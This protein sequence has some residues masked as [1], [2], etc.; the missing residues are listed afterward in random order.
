MKLYEIRFRFYAPKDSKEGILTYLLAESDE[1]IYEWIKSE[2]RGIYVGWM[3]HDNPEDED[4]YEE[5][6]KERIIECCGDMYD[7]ESYVSDTFYGATQY[8][9]GVVNDNITHEEFLELKRLG[10][11]TEEVL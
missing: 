3:Y 11:P 7:D 2:P 10:I 6:F 1:K 5:G 8:G 9:W 4:E